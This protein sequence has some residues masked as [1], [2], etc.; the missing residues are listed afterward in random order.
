M[1]PSERRK[2]IAAA[3]TAGV[4]TEDLATQFGVS[5]ETIRRDL[6]RLQK[7]GVLARVHGGAT[8]ADKPRAS[9]AAFGSRRTMHLEEKRAMGAVAASLAEPGRIVMIDVGTTALEAARALPADWTGTVITNSLLVCAE[10]AERPGLDVISLGGRMR[11]GDMACSGP[12]TLAALSELYADIA[13]LGSGGLDATAG[14]TDY[15]SDEVD[16][17]RLMIQ[18]SARA[19]VLADSTKFDV[20]S[21]RAVCP[22]RDLDGLISDRMPDAVLAQALR[23]ADVQVLTPPALSVAETG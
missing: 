18:H 19:F 15:Y 1:L 23:D 6:I 5:V 2:A 11:G 7:D 21:A 3:V 9:E 16:V 10:L 20:V 14:L 22:L 8:P 17:R 13:F 12:H 4:R